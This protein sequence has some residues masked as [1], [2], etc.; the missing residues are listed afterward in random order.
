MR[1]ASHLG[2][3]LYGWQRKY[4]V[5]GSLVTYFFAKYPLCHL[6]L[7]P[8]VDTGTGTCPRVQVSDT[9]KYSILRLN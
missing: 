5:F 2:F 1:F 8:D 4:L 9:F 7:G 3:L 6:D